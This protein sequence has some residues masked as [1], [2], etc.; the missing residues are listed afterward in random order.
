MFVPGVLW[1]VLQSFVPRCLGRRV[2]FGPSWCLSHVFQELRKN[3][4]E[5]TAL[6]FD[7][8]FAA[9][10]RHREAASADESELNAVDGNAGAKRRRV[11]D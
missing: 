8:A 5:R 6:P 1:A 7:S 2:P 3:A 9:A 4:L 10:A 11:S